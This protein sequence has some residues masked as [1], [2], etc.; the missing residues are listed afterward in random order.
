[1]IRV[2]ALLLYL[3]LLLSPAA[4]SAQTTPGPGGPTQ[5]EAQRALEVLEDPQKRAQLIDTLRAITKAAPPV[6]EAAAA[7]ALSLEPNSLGAQLLSQVAGWSDRMAVEMAAGADAVSDLPLL[8]RR[9]ERAIANPVLQQAVLTALWQLALAIGGALLAG[10]LA[11][12]ALR[13]PLGGLAGYAPENGIGHADDRAGVTTARRS[14]GTWRL[15]RRLPFALARLLL[16]LVPVAIFAGVANLLAA[17]LAAGTPRLV[18]LVLV[19]AYV[20][21]R[22]VLAIGEMLVSPRLGRLRLFYADDIHAENAIGWV[23]RLAGVAVFGSAAAEIGLLLGLDPR[24]HRILVRLVGLIIA[25]LLM[26]LVM[27]NRHAVASYLRGG[28][29]P[30]GPARWTSW[31]AGAWHYLALIVIAAGWILWAAGSH[32]GIGGLRLLIETVAVLVVARLVAILLLGLL[33][34]TVHHPDLATRATRYHPP[35]R[36]VLIVLIDLAAL[37]VLLQLWG[38]NAFFWF[39]SGR[40]GAHLLSALVTVAIAVIAAITVWEGTNAAIERRLARLGEAG[41]AA[42]AARLRTLLPM[43]RATLFATILVVVGLTALS[44]IGVNVAPLLAGAGVVGVAIGF[45]AQKLVQDVITGMFVLFENAIQVG[46]VITV[47]ALTG[48]VE[49]LSVRTIWL[50]GSDGSVHVIP[51]SAVT[52]ISNASRGLGNAT[53]SVTVPFYEDSDRVAAVLQEI[54]AGMRHD[55]DFAPL[56]LND[57]K[58]LG[59]DAVKAAGVTIAGEIACTSA[60]RWPVQREF[61]RRLQKRFQE[62]GIALSSG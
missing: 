5:T 48:T 17:M 33:D 23:R 12:L 29:A 2:I 25:E 27:R 21:Y 18:I 14:D 11:A 56:V 3:A 37:I 51:F 45:G 52:T 61:N 4:A 57:L 44:Q 42:H 49:Q 16:E 31:L 32:N 30:T 28:P 39:S 47:A 41:P 46:D 6:S 24:A 38:A 19:N 43:L 8:W 62:L 13:R 54:A 55:P 35:A 34:R 9:T 60:G 40:I 1:M 15:L 26:V 7:P 22:V 36:F 10:W 53:V 20:V 58:L 59:V 50:R